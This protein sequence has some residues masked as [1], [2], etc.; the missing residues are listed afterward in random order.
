MLGLLISIIFIGQANGAIKN[1]QKY[2]DNMNFDNAIIVTTTPI[3]QTPILEC[4]NQRLRATFSDIETIAILKRDM[5][6]RAMFE[7]SFLTSGSVYYC[8]EDFQHMFQDNSIIQGKFMNSKESCVIGYE[9]ANRYGVG[10]GDQIE[11]NYL[12]Y[13]VCGILKLSQYSE[14]IYLPMDSLSNMNYNGAEFYLFCKEASLDL[15]FQIEEYANSELGESKTVFGKDIIEDQKDRLYSLRGWGVSIIIS[16]LALF[17]GIVNVINIES[18]YFKS[19]YVTYGILKAYGASERMIFFKIY[20]LYGVVYLLAAIFGVFI[21]SLIQDTFIGSY[22]DIIIDD[23]I[24]IGYMVFSQIL[25][26]IFTYIRVKKL[27][28]NVIADIIFN[29]N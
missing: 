21:G 10:I 27:S 25:A 26:F 9:I 20:A 2:E 12:E 28:K 3:N 19:N 18:F 5:E 13:T 29:R 8:N 17:Y 15:Y 4:P 16:F 23:N 11:V 1:F 7:K 22:L 6:K 24:L 14:G